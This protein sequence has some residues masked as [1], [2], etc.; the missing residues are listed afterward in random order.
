MCSFSRYLMADHGPRKPNR[1]MGPSSCDFELSGKTQEVGMKSLY[2]CRAPF[3]PSFLLL[4]RDRW[5]ETWWR[6]GWL[7][8]SEVGGDCKEL[9]LFWELVCHTPFCNWLANWL[10][11]FSLDSQPSSE[12]LNTACQCVWRFI[13]YFC[14]LLS[15]SEC[16]LY[17]R[18]KI[19]EIDL[20]FY[21]FCQLQVQLRSPTSR[22][23]EWIG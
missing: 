22:V 3:F 2:L 12:S 17:S 1:D 20:F 16:S 14:V 7:A 23:R 18:N 21:P 19:P 6:G 4:R 15:P 13:I 5:H 8:A 10:A 9:Q 11:L